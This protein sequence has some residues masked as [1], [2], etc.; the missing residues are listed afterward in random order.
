MPSSQLE[1]AITFKRIDEFNRKSIFIKNM[2]KPNHNFFS[3]GK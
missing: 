2:R 1:S 3:L